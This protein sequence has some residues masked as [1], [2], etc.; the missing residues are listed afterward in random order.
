M[1]CFWIVRLESFS[2]LSSFTVI[3]HPD[4]LTAMAA[5][6]C[7]AQWMKH[8]C[9]VCLLAYMG[10]LV[11]RLGHRFEHCKAHLGKPWNKLA[12][13]AA[14]ARALGKINKT[15]LPWEPLAV[16]VSSLGDQQWAWLTQPLLRPVALEFAARC[17]LSYW[18]L[19]RIPSE[20]P[21]LGSD[22]CN[23]SLGP[24]QGL[25]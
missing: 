9:M 20:T 23:L 14:K 17:C 18:F 16:F 3:F 21:Q 13:L 2:E 24:A 25:E 15:T 5:A 7:E 12:D 6:E 22:N 4:S 19:F 1:K 8:S 10:D 11:I